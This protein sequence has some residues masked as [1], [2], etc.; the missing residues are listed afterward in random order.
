LTYGVGGGDHGGGGIVDSRRE[1]G[2]VEHERESAPAAHA[3]T[4][5]TLIGELEL[6]ED[7]LDRRRGGGES[8]SAVAGGRARGR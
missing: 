1:R 4:M 8:R 7:D 6:G 3:A 5:R 2:G